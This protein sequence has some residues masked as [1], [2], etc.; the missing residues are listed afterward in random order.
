MAFNMLT[1]E[2]IASVADVLLDFVKNVR[3]EISIHHT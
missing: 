3:S 2:Q 1:D